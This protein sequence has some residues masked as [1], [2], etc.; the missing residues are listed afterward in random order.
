[1]ARVTVQD[2]LNVVPNKFELVVLAAQRARNLFSGVE[3]LVDSDEMMHLV[4]LREIAD[5]KLNLAQLRKIASTNLGSGSNSDSSSDYIL[6]EDLLSYEEE[7]APDNAGVKISDT[8]EI[9]A[10]QNLDL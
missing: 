6:S 3:K 5:G 9:F 10:S 1:M 4:A 8:D 7:K 2:C